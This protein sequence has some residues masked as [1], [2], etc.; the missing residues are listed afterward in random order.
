M[1]ETLT[2]IPRPTA[3]RGVPR[4]PTRYAAMR[5]LPWPGVSAWPAPSAAAVRRASNARIGVA[6]ALRRMSGIAPSPPGTLAV[7]EAADESD[8]DPAGA[9][10]VAR[11]VVVP[12]G[13]AAP[14][15]DDPGRTVAVATSMGPIGS[16]SGTSSAGR[17]G[18]PG[19]AVND[20]DR[21]LGAPPRPVG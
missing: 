12:A 14:D 4:V 13:V 18:P 16:A 9:P 20:T 2:A 15:V 11:G 3:W 6:G 19:D 7:D 10:P 17:V 21:T 8:E 5:V 1:C